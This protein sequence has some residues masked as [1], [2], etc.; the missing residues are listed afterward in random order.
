[1]PHILRVREPQ[2]DA[3]ENLFEDGVVLPDARGNS[4]KFSLTGAK[5]GNYNFRVRFEKPRVVA[6]TLERTQR[7]RR[8]FVQ[9]P[10]AVPEQRRSA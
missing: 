10:K 2:A 8:R 3:R 4:A 1:M 5:P 9:K 6:E 7:P